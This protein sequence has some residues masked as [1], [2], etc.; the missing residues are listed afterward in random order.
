MVK[1]I[2]EE[3][4]VPELKPLPAYLKCA[5]LREYNT[6]HDTNSTSFGDVHEE[7]ENEIS[8]QV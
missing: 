4:P 2:N 6:L 8:I 7:K 5:S 3:A 1:A